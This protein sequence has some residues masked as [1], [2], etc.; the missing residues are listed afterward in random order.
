MWRFL[1]RNLRGNRGIVAVAISLTFFQVCADIL[2][3]FPLKFILDK[4]VHHIDPVVP[5]IGGL[6]YRLDPMGTRNGLNDNEVHTQMGVLVFSTLLLLGLSVISAVL[7][8][9]QV[10]IA[11]RVGSTL[12][13]RLRA[14]LF[15][16]LQ[17][18]PLHW[19]GRQ[20][21][22]DLVQR[23]TGNIL[24]VEK[25]VTD[26]LVDL[27]GGILTLVG[28]LVVMLLLNWQ[29]TVLCMV[30]A[31]ALFWSVIRYTL[32]IKRAS[33]ARARAA[34]QVAEVATEDIGAIT[35]VKAF[36]LEERE[37]THFRRYSTRL[38]AASW[39]AGRLQAEFTPIVAI[40]IGLSSATIISVG[41]WIAAGHGHTFGIGPFFIADG[42]LTTGSL[43]IFLSYSKQLYQ[44]MRNLSK[45]M[46]IASGAAAGA[47]RIEE[48]LDQAPEV[49]D[50][51]VAHTGPDRVRGEV[52]FRDVI[53]GYT[54]RRPVLTGI[55]LHVPQG[56]RVALVGLSGSGKTTMVKLIP[57]FYE[58]WG[59]TI[60]V[61]GVDVR[62]YPLEMLRR[63]ISLV[64]QDSVLFEGT[65]R[66][67]IALGR[68]DASDRDIV[69]AARL[70]HIHDQIAAL[71]DGYA[72][73]VREQGKNFSSGQR[74]RLAIA[75]AILR[76]AP[77]LILDEP[78]ANLDVEAEGE[79]MRAIERLV[80]GRTVLMISHRLSTLGN[81]DE[82]VV[83][84]KGRIVERG[85][86]SALKR[87]RGVFAGLLEEQSRY[88]A[89]RLADE[90]ER[91]LVPAFGHGHGNGS[92]RRN[93]GAAPSGRS[94]IA[95]ELAT[96]LAVTGEDAPPASILR[97]GWRR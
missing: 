26:G 43:T 96:A 91:V 63:N 77:I 70:A 74:Q 23:I 66:E 50:A 11:A 68:E 2:S 38:F 20:R 83:L 17:H 27:L 71:P 35:E 7:S 61:D 53:F 30:I 90:R 4:I 84:Q 64:L 72:S 10:I 76:D 56:R 62:N 21:T 79:V 28:I 41:G 92:G 87:A 16:H 88:S 36:T 93:G 22:G 18:L 69:T 45:L 94:L 81:V 32:A 31:P 40:L 65:V 78:T 42:T 29:F 60:T 44:P 6:L 8:Y 58:V 48:V 85:T 37:S 13:D 47:A 33:K 12:S 3:A 39:R 52:V 95:A 1:H 55:D 25:L 97:R 5:L 15:D 46:N 73:Q 75:R 59:G 24:D 19:H 80:V 54:D 51:P 49:T 82:I 9:V 57:R 86:Y 67:N 34:G 89:E 14:R